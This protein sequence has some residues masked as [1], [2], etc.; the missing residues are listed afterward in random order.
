MRRTIG[1]FTSHDSLERNML[2]VSLSE[3]ILFRYFIAMHIQHR[4]RTMCHIK[5]TKKKMRGGQGD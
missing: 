5:S 2:L 4:I 3:T 1:A